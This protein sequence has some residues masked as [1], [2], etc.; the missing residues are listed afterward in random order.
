MNWEFFCDNNSQEIFPGS[1]EF[2]G[3]CDCGSVSR[4]LLHLIHSVAPTW[5]F[6]RCLRE[7]LSTEQEACGFCCP[8]ISPEWTAASREDSKD[9]LA[10][11]GSLPLRLLITASQPKESRDACVVSPALIT[12]IFL[13][14]RQN[15]RLEVLYKNCTFSINTFFP[16]HFA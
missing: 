7:V 15:E 6:V 3:P 5:P 16:L 11:Q 12:Y 8:L 2:W 1:C 4:G 13:L 14:H 10:G 9:Q